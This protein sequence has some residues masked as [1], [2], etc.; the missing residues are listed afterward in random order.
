MKCRVLVF[1][2]GFGLA[3]ALSASA[4]PAV[5]GGLV[6][7]YSFDDI[8][9]GDDVIVEDGSGN[10][11]DGKVLAEGDA[12]MT[13]VP[14]V[15]GNCAS[16][17]II[18][19]DK[20]NYAAIEIVDKILN[21][22]DEP[23]P[24]DIPTSALTLA[25]WVNTSMSGDQA[26]FCPGSYDETCSWRDDLQAYVNWPYHL[27]VRDNYYRTTLRDAGMT[28]VV[29]AKVGDPGGVNP[30]VDPIYDEWSHIAWTFSQADASWKFYLNGEAVSSGAPAGAGQIA[31]DWG[32]RRVARPEYRH[33]P[34]IRRRDG[35]SLH[36][37][38]CA[39]RQ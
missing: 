39:Q 37:Q 2:I 3:I 25:L 10:D 12:S 1:A 16:Y 31:D 18:T 27:E 7:Y 35:R 17:N 30:E 4:D 36:V 8:T 33:W 19:E 32:R 5:T 11:M 29:N 38:A 6:F 34:S 20:T 15:Y 24:A 14:G 23:N 28:T 9:T 22:G 21:N 26:T 13:F